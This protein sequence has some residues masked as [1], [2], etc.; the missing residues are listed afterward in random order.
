MPGSVMVCK[1]CGGTF[2]IRRR[3]G[4][5]RKRN[6]VKTMWCPWCKQ[7]TQHVEKF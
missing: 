5:R 2:P 3:R 6:H 1:R 4:R 7:V